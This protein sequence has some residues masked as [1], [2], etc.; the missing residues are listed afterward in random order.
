MRNCY[1]LK[2]VYLC[3]EQRHLPIAFATDSVAS[4]IS[5]LS[6]KFMMPGMISTPRKAYNATR[7][8]HEGIHVTAV[9]THPQTTGLFH[10]LQLALCTS[11]SSSPSQKVWGLFYM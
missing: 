4:D 5:S 7:K 1:Y 9:C 2:M 11:H 3:S 8:K 6:L 10:V